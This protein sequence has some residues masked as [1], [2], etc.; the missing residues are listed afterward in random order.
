VDQHSHLPRPQCSITSTSTRHTA[1]P[2]CTC[3]RLH[4]PCHMI[5]FFC[6][7]R[8]W[9]RTAPI[10]VLLLCFFAITLAFQRCPLPP[11]LLSSRANL[12]RN[13]SAA[14]PAAARALHAMRLQPS[15][16]AINNCGEVTKMSDA[17]K[18]NNR[19]TFDS[20]LEGNAASLHG[21][22]VLLLSD[23]TDYNALAYTGEQLVE[24]AL[25]ATCALS[26]RTIFSFIFSPMLQTATCAAAS[27]RT[28]ACTLV[29]ALCICIS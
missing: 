3:W 13:T 12:V 19:R 22:R 27:P 5:L 17:L 15:Q 21:L 14:L 29:K 24:P 18:D 9:S 2:C 23:S 6:T 20:L 7:G 25:H 10:F 8:V 16:G 11:S 1:K 28:P 26:E 4:L